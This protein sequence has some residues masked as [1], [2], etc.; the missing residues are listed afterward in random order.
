MPSVES[1]A[2]DLARELRA[3]GVPAAPL[4]IVLGSGLGGLTERLEEASVVPADSLEHSPRSTV[5]GHAGRLVH[6]RLGGVS[7]VVQ[8]GRIHLYEGRSVHEV[9]RMVRAMAELGVRGLLLTNAAGSIEPGWA[10][11]ELMRL[12]DH[13]NLQGVAPLPRG[14]GAAARIYDADLAACLER[15]ADRIGLGLRRGVYAGLLG[16]AYETPA[17]IEM[18]RRLGAHAVGMST[19]AEASAAHA[20][21]MR[22][23]AIATL[24]N[25]AAG[26][27]P[28]PL[29]HEDVLEAGQAAAGSLVRLLEESAG[30]LARILAA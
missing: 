5:P 3:R 22:V 10:P 25:Y 8:Q 2:K 19:V 30:E 14:R 20:A 13:L 4:G 15:H 17:E 24:S 6:G 12:E 27:S 21:G 28:E 9:T 7:V 23:A 11:G 26:I 16:P 29:R 18:L 1:R